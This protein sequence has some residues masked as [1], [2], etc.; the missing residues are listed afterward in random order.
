[1]REPAS[2]PRSARLFPASLA[3][4][5]GLAVLA[6]IALFAG[7]LRLMG[8]GDLA[9]TLSEAAF[10]RSLGLSMGTSL[11]T[12]ALVTVL[13]VPAAYALSRFRFP[14]HGTVDLLLSLP[15]VLPAST[16]GLM[17]LVA[18][19]WEP[20]LWLQ[21]AIGFRLAYSLPGIV[22]AQS[23]IALAVG[24]RAWKAAFDD[25]DRR[26]EHVARSLGS[27]RGRTFLRVTLPAA[28]GGLAAGALLAWSRALAEFGAVLIFCSAIRG[29]TDILPV[30]M[31]LDV[32]A[33]D[34]ERAVVIGFSLALM[35]VLILGAMRLL[36]AT[37]AAR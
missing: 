16:I 26:T 31:F 15:V 28:R 34:L 1:M 33:G 4:L 23:V 2:R 25:V 13:G 11:V 6:T 24:V 27:S 22:V 19:Q 10:W 5:L 7:N 37:R 29:R 21:E 30:A 9:R 12:T 14:G 8:L 32:N 35:S 17:L 3:S 36:G 20:V 18:F